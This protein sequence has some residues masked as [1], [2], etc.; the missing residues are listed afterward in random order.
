VAQNK[1]DQ[2][3]SYTQQ[4]KENS[5][6]ILD[7]I[8]LIKQLQLVGYRPH[9]PILYAGTVIVIVIVE[10]Q[11]QRILNAMPETCHLCISEQN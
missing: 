7:G 9:S 8:K 5:I 1:P 3:Q 6:P 10:A 2:H 11:Q 4:D